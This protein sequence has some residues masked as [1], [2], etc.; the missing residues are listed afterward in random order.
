M[1]Q[2]SEVKNLLFIQNL[3]GRFFPYLVAIR[4]PKKFGIEKILSHSSTTSATRFW[5]KKWPKV[6]QK[7]ARAVFT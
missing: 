7:V 6:D 4:H 5:N 2:F 3:N 1:W